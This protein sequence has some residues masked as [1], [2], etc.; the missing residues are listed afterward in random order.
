MGVCGESGYAD[1][2]GFEGAY[3]ETFERRNHGACGERMERERESNGIRMDE[4]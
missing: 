2:C 3:R 4:L 1:S